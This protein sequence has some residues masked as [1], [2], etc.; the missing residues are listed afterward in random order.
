MRG[1]VHG[2]SVQND[3]RLPGTG[4]LYRHA[5]SAPAP[6]WV[7]GAF[8]FYNSMTFDQIRINRI[9][10]NSQDYGSHNR[11]KNSPKTASS[12][13]MAAESKVFFESCALC[14][15]LDSQRFFRYA[16]ILSTYKGHA[17]NYT[18]TLFSG[19]AKQILTI[20]GQ[21]NPGHDSRSGNDTLSW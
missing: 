21:W 14:A 12:R 18:R 3:C 5:Q 16:I 6:R 2:H 1:L 8:L 13:E 4:D 10:E 7:F 15:P 19:L 17:N 9:I 20:V 11:L